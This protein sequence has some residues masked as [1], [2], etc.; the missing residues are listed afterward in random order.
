MQKELDLPKFADED[1]ER[2]FWANVDLGD[3]MDPEDFEP[4]AFPNLK[5]TTRPVSIRFPVYVIDAVKERANEMGCPI[6]RSSKRRL[7]RRLW[8][9]VKRSDAAGADS[10]NRAAPIS[11]RRILLQLLLHPPIEQRSQRHAL[12]FRRP[13]QQIVLSIREADHILR[14][15][16]L[17]NSHLNWRKV[18]GVV[19]SVVGLP[20]IRHLLEGIKCLWQRVYHILIF[21]HSVVFPSAAYP[22]R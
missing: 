7:L 8:A 3:Y 20:E 13:L 14:A 18:L 4:V 2:E 11:T 6:R 22:V 19:G 15:G 1:E 9:T 16:M 17:C 5:P 12:P 21:V 10:R